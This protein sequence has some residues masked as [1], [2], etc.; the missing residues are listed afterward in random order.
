MKKIYL[1]GLP[2]LLLF[3]GCETARNVLGSMGNGNLSTQE[4]AMGLKEALQLGT[5]S[6]TFR[7]GKSDGF[8]KI[9]QFCL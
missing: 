7:L 2:F 9:K 5:D 8:F 4:V 3:T 6:A 1:A